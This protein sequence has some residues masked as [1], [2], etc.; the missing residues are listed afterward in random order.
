MANIIIQ[1]HFYN[2]EVSAQEALQI[3]NDGE[4]YPKAG[5]HSYCAIGKISGLYFL[6]HDSVI[7]GYLGNAIE[8]EFIV[9][10]GVV[11]NVDTTL[12]NKIDEMSGTLDTLLISTLG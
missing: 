10:P 8:M 1:G 12:K 9:T 11:E 6:P 5:T 3:I 2:T 4:G 7:Q